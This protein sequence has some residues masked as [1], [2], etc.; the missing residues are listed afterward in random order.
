MLSL[1]VSSVDTSSVELMSKLVATTARVNKAAKVLNW[2]TSDNGFDCDFKTGRLDPKMRDLFACQNVD[3]VGNLATILAGNPWIEKVEVKTKSDLDLTLEKLLTLEAAYNKMMEV[4]QEAVVNVR[5]LAPQPDS[6]ARTKFVTKMHSMA[7][8]DGIYRFYFN[9]AIKTANGKNVVREL[10]HR[11]GIFISTPDVISRRMVGGPPGVI[12][13]ADQL[14]FDNGQWFILVPN[15]DIAKGLR[16]IMMAMMR[17]TRE[18]A[19][20]REGRRKVPAK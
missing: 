7:S 5:R 6:I 11:P 2:M 8:K 16:H 4:W 19:R 15:L 3:L 20:E 12:F 9:G 17:E 13:E 1:S 18:A 14:G 10:I